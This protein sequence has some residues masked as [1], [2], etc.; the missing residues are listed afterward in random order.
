[1]NQID[2]HQ[3]N[4]V[5]TIDKFGYHITYRMDRLNKKRIRSWKRAFD[6]KDIGTKSTN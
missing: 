5:S 2:Y 1:M 4:Y 6:E 3:S